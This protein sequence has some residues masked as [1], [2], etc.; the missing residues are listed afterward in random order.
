[1]KTACPLDCYDACSVI[2]EGDK[3]VGDKEHP[4]TKGHLCY[5]LNHYF[6][7][8]QLQSAYYEG[9][10]VSLERALDILEEKIKSSQ[11]ILH[12]RGSGNVG[13]MQAIT[14]LFFSAIGA[15]LTEGS[16]C[17]AAGQFGIEKGRGKNLILPLEQIEKSE[18]VIVWGRNV[19][20]TNHHLIPYLQGKTLVV[21]D[22]VKT[23]L[24]KNASMHLQI[25]PRTDLEL[26][27][28]LARFVY[29]QNREDEEFIEK[30]TEDYN[31]YTDFIRSYRMV[32]TTE[33]IGVDLV[34][35]ATLAELMMDMKTVILVGNGVQK[36][37]HGTEVVRA[38]DSL[39][40]ML[41]LFGKEGCGVSFLGDTSVGLEDPFRVKAKRVP[42]ATVD[43]GF[44]DL[45]FIQGSNPVVTMPASKRVKEGLQKSFTV[46]FGLYNDETAQLADLVI[47]AKNFLQKS[48]IRFSY[49]HE[50]VELMPKLQENDKALSEYEFTKEM[51]RRFGLGELKA[52]EEYVE[53]FTKQLKK[54]G[55]YYLLPSYEEV[56]YKQGFEEPF[57]FIDEVEDEFDILQEGYY[58]I[59]PKAK[60]AINSQF[61]RDPYLYVPLRSGLHDGDRVIVRSQW[62]ETEMEVKL[63]AELRD[64]CVLAYSG[65]L[66][67]FVTPPMTDEHGNNA[68]FQEVKV[69]IKKVS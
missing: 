61:K 63:L 44:Y 14:D 41:G 69:S 37:A 68:V 49:G 24:A 56:P 9:E 26:A 53:I 54:R 33:K 38:I 1:M 16:L 3:L 66:I 65:S 40:A 11:E 15:T 62:G 27:C 29:M 55:E 8:P 6:D 22:P 17:D 32:P 12:F 57:C 67:N 39:A 13:K 45:C 25:T 28:M 21:I 50:F 7:Y 30:H 58:L 4:F 35:I 43:F 10:P 31:F 52:E 36:Y 20:Y 47:P 34:D 19:G 23:N 2:L 51:M 64:D 48:D 46:V 5:K 59:T 42:K 18:L 60:N